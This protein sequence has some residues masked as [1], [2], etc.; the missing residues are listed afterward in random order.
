MTDTTEKRELYRFA[1]GEILGEGG[2]PGIVTLLTSADEDTDYDG[3]IYVATPMG[4]S[5]VESKD[6]MPRS[7]LE[8]SFDINNALARRWL[9][10][11]VEAQVTVT[12]FEMHNQSDSDTNILWKGR[13]VKVQPVG[14]QIKIVFESV[15][16]SL[17]RPG[18]KA[19][20]LRSCRH[21]LYGRGCNLN[22]FDFQESG[23]ITAISGSTITVPAADAFPDGYFTT[24]MLEA[25][26]GSLRFIQN[27]VGS[28]IT[29]IRSMQ[30]LE[31]TDAVFL[32]PGCFRDRTTCNDK[33]NNLP[34]YGG[35]DWI[36]LRNPIDGS[37]IV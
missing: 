20:F 5:D 25:P 2:D 21:S 37:S 16:T 35:F 27:H 33:F 34:N 10:D 23:T 31:V 4:R 14:S 22:R 29:L 3:D 36:P 6:K 1:E 24:G 28:Q 15:F 19:R 17:R 32:Y 7:S 13:M 12:V 9:T 30:V 11:R 18:L 26:D 8:I